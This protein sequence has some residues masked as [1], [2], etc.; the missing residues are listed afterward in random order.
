MEEELLRREEADLT[1]FVDDPL[2]FARHCWPGSKLYDRQEDIILSVKD[3][4]ETFVVAGHQLGKDW[5]GGLT[6]LWFLLTR[7]PVRVVTTSVKDDHLMVL[8]AEIGRFIDTSEVPLSHKRGGQLVVNHREIKKLVGGEV[9]KVSYLI[10]MVS[11]KGEGLAGHHAPHT[12]LIVDEASGVDDTVYER[13]STWAKKILV[14]GNPYPC[15]NFFFK[16]VKG[17]DIPA[18]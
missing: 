5:I 11:A 9:C 14:V 8:W 1:R 13:A 18:K 17:G 6:A 10:G 3:N 16:A 7:H 15:H 4:A 12:L 2:G